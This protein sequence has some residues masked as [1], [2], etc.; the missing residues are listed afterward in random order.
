MTE[1]KILAVF[2]EEGM[3]L[4]QAGKLK[5]SKGGLRWP[6]GELFELAD[7]Q[8]ALP[9]KADGGSAAIRQAVAQLT[10]Q[11]K[12]LQTGLQGKV[13][14]LDR[15]ADKIHFLSGISLALS[16]ADLVVTAVGFAVVCRKL[17]AMTDD[18]RHI[19]DQFDRLYHDLVQGQEERAYRSYMRQ[20]KG[21]LIA[22]EEHRGEGTQEE[23]YTMKRREIHTL[24]GDVGDLL[25]HIPDQFSKGGMTAEEG[26][27]VCEI[28]FTLLPL[29]SREIMEV[30]ECHAGRFGRMPE[31]YA[32][33]MAPLSALAGEEFQNALRQYLVFACP[34]ASPL[35]KV[36][37]RDRVNEILANI[38]KAQVSCA[39]LCTAMAARRLHSLDELKLQP[40]GVGSWEQGLAA[41]PVL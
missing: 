29:Y 33:W 39:K 4:Y 3:R 8:L 2:S 28:L 41:L 32:D 17:D 30:C 20:M 36:E 31:E 6:N 27:L 22:F 14:H 26:E 13:K 16:A 9:D 35:Q 18:L 7:V 23:Y 24:L 1:E 11:Y 5:L 12:F 40:I 25:Y 19:N 38:L 10:G 37:I 15:M 21:D 34:A